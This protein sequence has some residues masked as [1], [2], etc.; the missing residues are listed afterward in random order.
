MKSMDGN[1]AA[2]YVAYAFTDVAAIYPITPSSTM[3]EE[4][5]DWSAHGKKN[6]FG[7]EVRV[8]ELQSEAGASGAVHGSLAAG[9]LT[10]TFTASQGLLLMIPNM[11]KIAGELLPGVF[12]VSARA[13]AGHALS[14]F[15]DHS[16]VMATRQTGFALLASGSVQEVMDL[17]AVAHL[18]AIKS[19]VPFVHFFDGFRTSHE[20][21]KIEVI[22]YDQFAKLVD[23][24]A[25]KAFRDRSLN[26]EHPVTRGTAQ[27]PDIFFQAKEASNGFYDSLPEIVVKYMDEINNI[28][29][30]TY[31]PFNYYGAPDAEKIIIAMG[32]V[33]ETIEETIDYLMEKGEKVGVVKVHLYRP[34]TEKYF[35]DVLPKTVKKIAVLDRTKEPGSIGEPLYMDIKSMFYNKTEKPLIVGGRY[36]LGSKDTTPSQIVAVYANLDMNEPKDGFTIGIVDDVTYKSLPLDNKIESSQAGT[37]RCKF[38]GL[39]SDGTVGANKNAIKIIG[40]KTNLYTQGYFSY[41]SKKSGGVTI[42]HLRFGDK[43]IKSTY[44]IS[45]ADFTSCSQQSYV[46]KYD[47]LKGLKK[48]GTFLLNTLWNADELDKYLPSEMKKYIADNE[49]NFYTINATEIAEKLGLENRTNMIMQSAFFK[50]AEVI[51]LDDAVMF[52]KEAIYETYGNKGDQIVKMNEDAV[53]K[54]I[55]ELVKIEIPSTWSGSASKDENGT[56]DR[57]EFIKNVLDPM[58]RQEGDALPVSTFVGREDGTFPMGT[59]AYEKRGIAVNVPEWQKE[60]CIQCNQCAFVCPHAVIRPFLVNEAEKSAA[61]DTFE[62]IKATGKGFEG[63]EYRIQISS[64]DCTGCGNCADICPAKQKALVMKPIASQTDIQIPNWEYAI[65]NIG[66]K[67]NLMDKKTLKGSQFAFPYLEFSGACAGCGETPYAKVITQLFGDRMMIANATGCSSIWGASAPSTVY[68]Q[69]ADG[70][71]PSWANSLFEDNAEYGY[72]MTMGVNQIRSSIKDKMNTLLGK[73]CLDETV[74]ETL[75]TWLQT[76]DDG[77]NS[78]ENS[79]K[80]VK[81]LQSVKSCEGCESEIKDILD[82]KD[83]LVKKSVWI[84]G[85]DGW[86]YDIGYGGLDHV[87][88]SGEDVNVLVFDTEVYSNTGGQ[89]SKAT[90][91]A[92]TAK[93]AAAGKHVKKKDL[94]LIATTYGYIYVAQ[95]AMGSNKNQFMKAIVEAESYKGP[96]LIIAYAPCINHG[97][98]E[99]MGRTQNQMKRAVDSGYWHLYRFDP[100]L[101]EEGKNPFVLDSKE[102]TESFRDFLMS[103]V[104]Y[105]TLQ[106]QFPD[107]AE[108]LFVKA[109]KDA[110]ER[111][112]SY[113]RM[114]EM[115]Y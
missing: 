94:G 18:T 3:A 17:A 15:G 44:L 78:N 115:K 30:R 85:G 29:G 1:T 111:Y 13:V 34:F 82:K 91:T 71:G 112:N 102:P 58:N 63:L 51:P 89:S 20:I 45:E 93:F 40:D 80:V 62:T 108:E 41:D 97:I 84:V 106:R 73:D 47:L 5:D 42:S 66:I 4:V 7:Q 67:D 57:P 77:D 19:R 23:H 87:L 81:A 10:T 90:P 76:M 100:R 24:D 8:T 56:S 64:L 21:Q 35:F 43:P 96:S 36:G 46:D 55:T 53:D 11:Y 54:G 107:V 105:T 92:A 86:A 16:D 114:V 88:A 22:E 59:S 95:V 25:I 110:K 37:I 101:K 60:N 32:S 14:I 98:M 61:P 38:W 27:N 68:C 6:I 74:K 12:H 99:G 75:K 26:P 2:A 69:D 109:E 9:A 72:G 104:R 65:K 39:G 83:Y 70:K 113:K 28:T 50:L 48:G 103:E 33:T 31:K 52:S 79:A 49:I